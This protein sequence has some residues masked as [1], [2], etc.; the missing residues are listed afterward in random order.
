ML[1][2]SSLQ[3]DERTIF[4]FDAPSRFAGLEPIAYV[5]S[6]RRRSVP[7]FLLWASLAPSCLPQVMYGSASMF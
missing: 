4:A 7:C 2:E 5:D 6:S 1:I 3:I